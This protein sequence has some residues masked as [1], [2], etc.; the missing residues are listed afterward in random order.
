MVG[1][2]EVPSLSESLQHSE[3]MQLGDGILCQL[4]FIGETHSL[5]LD[6]VYALELIYQDEVRVG[7][8]LL[9]LH[10]RTLVVLLSSLRDYLWSVSPDN[11][12]IFLEV[13]VVT[14]FLHSSILLGIG[15]APDDLPLFLGIL[16]CLEESLLLF[17]LLINLI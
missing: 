12:H 10:E 14:Y 17:D 15:L 5:Q 4:F 16:L 1:H 3:L 6:L 2:L 13:H 9:L 11:H 7:L 8:L